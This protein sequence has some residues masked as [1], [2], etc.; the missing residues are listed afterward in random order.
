[1]ERARISLGAKE[2]T[3]LI[4]EGQGAELVGHFCRARYQFSTAELRDMLARATRGK[5]ET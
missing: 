3:G 2:L 5:P 4:E 1:M